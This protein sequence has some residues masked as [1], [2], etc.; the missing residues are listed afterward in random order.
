MGEP[1]RIA[2][3]TL[4]ARGGPSG[5][6]EAMGRSLVQ[7]PGEGPPAEDH[8][9]EVTPREGAGARVSTP[10]SSLLWQG[11]PLAK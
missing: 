11:S 7:R 5:E 4:A 10:P 9:P 6:G 1:R 3:A 2:A 8:Q